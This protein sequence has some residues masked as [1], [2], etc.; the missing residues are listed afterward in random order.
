[1]SSRIHSRCNG[2]LAPLRSL[3]AVFKPSAPSARLQLHP[4][5]DTRSARAC[6]RIPTRFARGRA[7]ARRTHLPRQD[8]LN[9][10]RLLDLYANPDAIYTWLYQHLLICISRHC[11]WDK[12]DFRVLAVVAAG[13]RGRVV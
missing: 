10:V 12:E 3:A 11:Q 6:L 5:F 2:L 13:G 7:H 9:L 8:L 4:S 1:M